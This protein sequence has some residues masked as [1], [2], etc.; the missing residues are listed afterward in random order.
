MAIDFR[1]SL[2]IELER[3]QRELDSLI[4]LLR[5]VQ[6]TGVPSEGVIDI[7]K[8]ALSDFSSTARRGGPAVHA[9]IAELRE[10]GLSLR[11]I[12]EQVHLSHTAV[13]KALRR[14]RESKEGWTEGAKQSVKVEDKLEDQA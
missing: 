8:L 14:T 11:E 6:V 13:W 1:R 10:R 4:A 2:I 9:E 12:G 7:E 3:R 5:E